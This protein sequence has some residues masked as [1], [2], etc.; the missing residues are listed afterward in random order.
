M[1]VVGITHTYYA[2]SYVRA[3]S[4]ILRECFAK[5]RWSCLFSA[6]N[7][8]L[9]RTQRHNSSAHKVLLVVP[10]RIT[11]A[12]R[13]GNPKVCTAETRGSRIHVRGMFC[14]PISCSDMQYAGN[15]L[16]VMSIPAGDVQYSPVHFPDARWR[17]IAYV[18]FNLYIFYVNPRIFLRLRTHTTRSVRPHA[19]A[20]RVC[21]YKTQWSQ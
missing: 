16:L 20:V 13:R 4:N 3:R 17:L 18:L 6:F 2:R 1:W 15:V 8:C 14:F 10:A 5:F 21:I 9:F 7:L 19:R 11:R 12:I